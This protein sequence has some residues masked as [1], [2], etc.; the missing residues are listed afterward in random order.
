MPYKH[1]AAHLKKT[2]LAC[3]LHYHQLSHGSRRR[4]RGASV[5]STNS[6]TSSG[7]CS[8]DSSPRSQYQQRY[9]LDASD[10]FRQSPVCFGGANMPSPYNS[11]KTLLPKPMTMTLAE[12]HSLPLSTATPPNGPVDPSRLRAIYD[13]HRSTFWSTI[14]QDY[15]ADASPGQLEAMWQV[16]STPVI[17]PPT[18]G[19]SPDRMRQSLKPV[20]VPN[21]TPYTSAGTYPS[22]NPFSY[23]TADAVSAPDRMGYFTPP[24]RI[25]HYGHP[26][27][28]G[29]GTWAHQTSLG[30]PIAISSLLTENKCPRGSACSGANCG[31]GHC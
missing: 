29:D 14:A 21:F 16:Q 12:Q 26:G 2:E 3:R 8:S 1:I 19:D 23:A 4:K 5:S 24:T 28:S 27:L 25:G 11:Q 30:P 6:Y 9:G 10:A 18:P 20:Q 31:H 17:R 13:Q 7:T 15:G 22:V